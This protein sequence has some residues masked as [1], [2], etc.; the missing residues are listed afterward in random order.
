MV[1]CLIQGLYLPF[2]W[3][4]VGQAQTPRFVETGSKIED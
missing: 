1:L 3:P 2:F 4:I